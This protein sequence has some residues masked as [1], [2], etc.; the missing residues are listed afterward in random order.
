MVRKLNLALISSAAV[1]VL[2]V[3]TTNVGEGNTNQG[4]KG[5]YNPTPR[6][7]GNEIEEP[8]IFIF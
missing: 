3:K 4:G 1:G 8:T 2:H 7:L 6:S 5:S